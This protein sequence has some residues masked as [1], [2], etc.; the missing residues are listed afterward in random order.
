MFHYTVGMG[1]SV[2]VDDAIRMYAVRTVAEAAD[3][4]GVRRENNTDIP[5]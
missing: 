5:S 1:H 3:V 2:A 4:V